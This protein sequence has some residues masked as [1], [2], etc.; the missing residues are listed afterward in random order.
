MLLINDL[1]GAAFA[2]AV[3][4]VRHSR[5]ERAALLVAEF[6]DMTMK[7][8]LLRVDRFDDEGC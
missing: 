1:G 5:F 7:R 6:P 3:R 8:A 2:E 4:E